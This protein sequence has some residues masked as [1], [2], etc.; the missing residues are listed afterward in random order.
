M[1]LLRSRTFFRAIA[2]LGYGDRRNAQIVGRM[3]QE[4]VQN[5]S[6]L[7]LDDEDADVRVQEVLH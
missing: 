1:I 7:L 2:Q 3:F 5:A 4:V 6:R